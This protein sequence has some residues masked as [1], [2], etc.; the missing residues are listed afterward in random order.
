MVPYTITSWDEFQTIA[1]QPSN[2]PEIVWELR[3]EFHPWQLKIGIGIGSLRQLP[4]LG[5]AVNE[6]AMGEAFVRAREAMNEVA[7][8]K[9]KYRIRTRLH[10][11]GGT[12]EHAINMIYDLVDTLLYGMT[13]RQWQTIMAY[14]RARKVEAAARQLGI[15]VSTASRNLQRG[16]YWQIVAARERLRE[17]LTLHPSVQEAGI[18]RGRPTR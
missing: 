11:R 14:E 7:A 9:E 10:A 18:V 12:I 5:E 3:R 2:L 17:I 13:D 8:A 15:D 16:Y 6:T 4:Q 1:S